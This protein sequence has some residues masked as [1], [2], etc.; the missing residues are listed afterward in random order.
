M[1]ELNQPQAEAVAHL[2]GPLLIFAGAGSGKTR[3]ITFRI[4]N[5]LA[6]RGRGVSMSDLGNDPK[7]F[8]P[9]HVEMTVSEEGRKPE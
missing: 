8:R 4:A 9:W 5:L 1:D 7:D 3:T 2:G 6:T